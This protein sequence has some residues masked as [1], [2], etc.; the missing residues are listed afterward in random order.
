M[1]SSAKEDLP[2]LGHSKLSFTFGYIAS[3][4]LVSRGIEKTEFKYQN[5]WTQ[6]RIIRGLVWSAST[7]VSRIKWQLVGS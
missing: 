2:K 5:V 1:T 6:P 3:I 4:V 7:T